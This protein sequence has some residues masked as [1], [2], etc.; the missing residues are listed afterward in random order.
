MRTQN[1]DSS[2]I[3]GWAN[4]NGIAVSARGRISA[5]IQEQYSAAA[6]AGDET[7]AE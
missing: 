2:A 3:R 4:E 1:S 5:S 6:A 7:A